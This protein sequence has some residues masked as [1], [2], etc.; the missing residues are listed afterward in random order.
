MNRTINE[1]AKCVRTRMRV[2][3]WCC[4]YYSEWITAD[5]E[6]NCILLG[7][8]DRG[9]GK[10]GTAAISEIRMVGEKVGSSDFVMRTCTQN[11]YRNE[12]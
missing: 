8:I 11:A 4:I 6:R 5:C 10:N 1:M 2:S 9:P 3:A 7:T 12:P